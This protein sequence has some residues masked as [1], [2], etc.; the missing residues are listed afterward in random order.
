MIQSLES[1]NRKECQDMLCYLFGNFKSLHFDFARLLNKP[2]T[3]KT[4]TNVLFLNIFLVTSI[5]LQN[6]FTK[7]DSIN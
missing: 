2:Q 4:S 3:G 5:F 6:Y 1:K 7:F